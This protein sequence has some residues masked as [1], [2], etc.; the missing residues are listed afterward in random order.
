MTQVCA[1]VT[2]HRARI[3]LTKPAVIH[4]VKR[5]SHCGHVR[6]FL[7]HN[8]GHYSSYRSVNNATQHVKVH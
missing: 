1:K 8:H 2:T 5:A 4:P 3:L 6:L 7:C